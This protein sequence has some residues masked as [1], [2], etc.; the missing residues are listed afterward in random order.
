[1]VFNWAV[2]AL[3]AI[4]VVPLAL[5]VGAGRAPPTELHVVLAVLVAWLAPSPLGRKARATDAAVTPPEGGSS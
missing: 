5:L 1:M 3:V 2:V 4:L